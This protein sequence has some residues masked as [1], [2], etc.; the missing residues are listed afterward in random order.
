M[1][2]SENRKTSKMLSFRLTPDEYEQL[3]AV[4]SVSGVSIPI[5]IRRSAFA[6][7]ALPV[8]AYEGRTPCKT[9]AEYTRILGAVGKIGNNLNQLTKIANLTKSAPAQKELRLLFAEIRAL[10]TDIIN[11]VS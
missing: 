4:A 11:G 3:A 9:A 6:A 1:S 8:P 10:R 7:A 2:K 5:F